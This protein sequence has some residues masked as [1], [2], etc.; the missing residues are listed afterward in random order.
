MPGDILICYCQLI[1]RRADERFSSVQERS[2]F[3]NILKAIKSFY[4]FKYFK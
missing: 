3:I 4:H 2:Q 1:Q